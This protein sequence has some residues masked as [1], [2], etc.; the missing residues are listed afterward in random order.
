MAPV[1]DMV[2]VDAILTFSELECSRAELIKGI[3]PTL[4]L[5]IFLA[6]VPIVL[7]LV[8]RYLAGNLSESRVD[9]DVGT[10][11]F[12][13]QFVVVFVFTTIIGAASAGSGA[14]PTGD[15]EADAAAAAAAQSK[16]SQFPIVDLLKQ[17]GTCPG[18]VVDTLGKSIPQQVRSGRLC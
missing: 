8:S 16:Q 13:F 15:A 10:K 12:I 17:L 11:Y 14:C 7:G 18:H 2:A 9:F 1:L 3:L 6:V 5:Q 4:A